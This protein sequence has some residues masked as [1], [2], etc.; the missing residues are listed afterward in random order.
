MIEGEQVEIVGHLVDCENHLGRSSII[1]LNAPLFNNFR[2]VDHRSIDWIIFRNV[3]YS[4]GKKAAGDASESIPLKVDK[5]KPKW[6]PKLLA[7]GNWFSETNYY[8][9]KKVVGNEHV[10][11]NSANDPG[12]DIE[13]DKDIFDYETN[14]G[15]IFETEE[16]ITRTEMVK[17]LLNAKECVFTAKFQKKVDDKHVLEVL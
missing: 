8:K 13:I 11:V 3:K 4:L 17:I 12:S 6:N 15:K 1:D 7:V 5:N 16:K 10:V 14:S 2:Q 9:V